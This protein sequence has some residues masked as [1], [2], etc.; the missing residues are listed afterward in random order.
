MNKDLLNQLPADEQ[1]LASK[2]NS[3]VD[4]LKISQVFEWELETQLMEKAKV[5]TQAA[6]PGFPKIIVPVGWAIAVVCGVLLLNWTIRTFVPSLPTGAGATALPE[7]S[8]EDQ[9]RQGNICSGPLALA[10][11]FDVFLT[12]PHKTDFVSLDPGKTIGELRSFRWSTDGKGLALVGNTNGGG[13]IYITEPDGGSIR[14]VLSGAA[15]DYLMGAAWSRDEK[16]FVAWSVRNTQSVYLL[17]ADGSGPVE[18]QMEPYLSETPQFTPDGK[19]IIFYGSTTSASGLF[20]ANLTNMETR[21]INPLVESG[22]AFAFSPDGSRLAYMAMDRNSGIAVLMVEDLETRAITSMPGGLPIPKGSGSSI[23]QAAHLS[24]SAD[25]KS[26]LFDFGRGA[27]DHSIYLAHLDGTELVKVVEAGYAPT[28]SADGKCLA[29]ISDQKVYLLDFA[30]RGTS[31]PLLF[32]DLP[33][34]RAVADYRLDQLQ[35]RP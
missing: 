25:G 26:I 3:L 23:P 2:L 7:L 12:N 32:A 11:G 4:D 13:N 8:F 14:S 34:G 28:L 18:K 31:A 29:Y 30:N 17:N 33:T 10:H 21:L 24:W 16:Q 6:Q 35:W 22:T 1:P 5:E 27:Y 19:S 9:V 15:L 20:E